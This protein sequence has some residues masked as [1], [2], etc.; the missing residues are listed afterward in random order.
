MHELVPFEIVGFV[1]GFYAFTLWWTWPREYWRYQREILQSPHF[2]ALASSAGLVSG[3]AF[4]FVDS[5][6]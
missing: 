2:W 6:L 4:W 3:S 5:V 1:F